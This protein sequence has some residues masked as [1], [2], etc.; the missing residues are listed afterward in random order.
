MRFIEKVVYK[1]R[2]I[3]YCYLR[4]KRFKRLGFLSLCDLKEIMVIRMF[5]KYYKLKIRGL[6]FYYFEYD[7]FLMYYII[8]RYFFFFF[9]NIW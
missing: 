8:L 9:E 2:Y 5:K 7:F 4:T 3:L 1:Y 6:C